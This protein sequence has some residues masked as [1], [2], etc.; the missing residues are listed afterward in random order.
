MKTQVYDI[1]N[2]L[3]KAKRTHGVESLN[4]ISLGQTSTSFYEFID[5]F[6][7]RPKIDVIFHMVFVLFLWQQDGCQN[8]QQLVRRGCV[9]F[10]EAAWIFTRQG[11]ISQVSQQGLTDWL[12][13]QGNDRTWVLNNKSVCNNTFNLVVYVCQL[14]G[15]HLVIIM[16]IMITKTLVP[17]QIWQDA[18]SWEGHQSFGAQAP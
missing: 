9:T 2:T 1:R 11:H 17:L 12:T 4:L 13:R 10:G 18:L 8:W 15:K 7:F 6:N 5:F 3:P 16:I 14:F